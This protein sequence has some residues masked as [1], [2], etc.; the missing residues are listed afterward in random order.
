MLDKVKDLVTTAEAKLKSEPNLMAEFKS[1]PV[2]TLEK[3]L[4]VDLPDDQIK[5]VAELLKTKL[6]GGAEAVTD[7]LGGLFK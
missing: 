6:G 3:I 1:E 4:G 2:K 7:L 5:A